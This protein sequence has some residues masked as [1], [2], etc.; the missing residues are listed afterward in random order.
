MG[1]GDQI[2]SDIDRK[3]AGM[4]S[5]GNHLGKDMERQA[6][7]NAPWTD[8]TGN[9]RRTINGGADQSARGVTLFL[10]HGSMVGTYLETGTP[11]YVIRPKSKKALRFVSGGEEIF[12]KRVNHPGI[13]PHPIVEPTADSNWPKIKQQVRRYWESS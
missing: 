12:A 3:I 5:L 8:R 4:Y 13:S 6:K 11:S 2:K 1:L 9:T 7:N 10:A